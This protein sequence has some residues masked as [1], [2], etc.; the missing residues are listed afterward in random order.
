MSVHPIDLNFMGLAGSICCYMVPHSGG[1][2]LVEC[3]PGSTLPALEKGLA[4][5]GFAIEDVTDVLLSHIHLDHAGASG[6][7]ARQGARIH[8]HPAGASHMLDPEKLL[9]SATRI[10]GEAMHTLWGD[11][12][13]VPEDQLFTVQDGSTI[14]IN[15]LSFLALEVPGHANHHHVYFLSDGPDRVCFSG[16]I[17]GVR[18]QGAHHIR[19]PMPP[20]EF[21]LELWR[22]SL[23]R[24]QAQPIT[25][26]A[27]THFGLFND[28]QW[29]LAAV[30][31]ALD[32]V[33]TW[34]DQIMPQD[35]PIEEL[36][37]RFLDWTTQRSQVEGLDQSLVEAYEAANPSPMSAYGIQRYW[38][39]HRHPA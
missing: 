11:F 4:A 23:M 19:L 31:R 25:H 29:H 34:I 13:P 12:L 24:I 17:G 26:I 35:P 14:N 3:G 20:P 38:R 6:W 9:N 18:L 33:E 2:A 21:H 10:Y 5:H 22:A 8:V 37:A 7:L 16:D 30:W 15:E 39:K 1:V 36:V 28:P 32:E 27:P